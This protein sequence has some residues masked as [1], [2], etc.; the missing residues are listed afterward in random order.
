[1]I[2][3]FNMEDDR[4]GKK[5]LIPDTGSKYRDENNEDLPC[6]LRHHQNNSDKFNDGKCNRAHLVSN[7]SVHFTLIS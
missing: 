6:N 7:V 2:L 1:M 4:I 3:Q 5:Y